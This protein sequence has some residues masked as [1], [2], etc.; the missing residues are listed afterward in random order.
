MNPTAE[1]FDLLQRA[2]QLAKCYRD[3]TGRPLGIVGEIAEAEA[4]RLLGLE[5]APVRTAGYDVVRKS[6]AGDQ[7][8]QVKGRVM[9]SEKLKGRMGSINTAHEFDGVLL[10]LLD[11]DL[12]ATRI[13]E[14]PRAKV[15]E[16]IT[17]P[18]SK[19]RNERGALAIPMFCRPTISHQVWPPR[20]PSKN[21]TA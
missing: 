18:G 12:N 14:A 4:V 20:P 8:L 5:L 3:L 13:F 1:L 10:V 21:P 15:I 7:H 6:P 16:A 11:Q 2:K 19:A 17:R 9:F